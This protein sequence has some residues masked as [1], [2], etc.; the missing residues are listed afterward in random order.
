[1]KL[2]TPIRGNSIKIKNGIHTVGREYIPAGQYRR[3]RAQKSR[4]KI[5]L[6]FLSQGG[7][8]DLGVAP[9][10]GLG[11]GSHFTQHDDGMGG[12]V[13]GIFLHGFQLQA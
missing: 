2:S 6:L 10:I 9:G 4:A 5:A 13:D 3:L 12:P 8:L 1:M 11:G 7:L